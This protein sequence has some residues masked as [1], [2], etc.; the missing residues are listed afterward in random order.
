MAEEGEDQQ[1][2]LEQLKRSMQYALIKNCDMNEE[3]RS[4]AV[5][6]VISATEKHQA[7]YELAARMVKDQVPCKR[8][9]PPVQLLLGVAQRSPQIRFRRWHAREA[10]QPQQSQPQ[11]SQ[12][13][14]QSHTPC[15]LLGLSP[16]PTPLPSFRAPSSS[17]HH[18]RACSLRA[19]PSRRQMDKKYNS[20]WIVA[21]GQGFSFEVTH[22]VK[23][24]LW[25][26][27]CDIGVLV[28]KAGARQ[29][30]T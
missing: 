21:I 15:C 2:S 12:Q 20:N 5:D 19:L 10:A 14:Q 3:M 8:A 18:R 11:Q 1:N 4:D 30:G 13:S 28:C 6:L 17:H 7:N 24:V 22:E 23:H 16:R 25:M 27:F 26:Y 29:A 9:R